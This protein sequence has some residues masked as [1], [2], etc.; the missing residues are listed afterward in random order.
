MLGTTDDM[1]CL[2]SDGKGE[3]VPLLSSNSP[4]VDGNV[5]SGPLSLLPHSS[6]SSSI[7]SGVLEG[8]R[9]EDIGTPLLETTGGG[10]ATSAANISAWVCR[11]LLAPTVAAGLDEARP[12]KSLP[13]GLL[14]GRK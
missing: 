5:S 12:G 2:E 8:C 10:L 4:G 6:V 9:P 11:M 7:S 3:T 14:A 1:I 13:F